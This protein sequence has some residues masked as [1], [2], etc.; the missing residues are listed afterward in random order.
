MMPT[1]WPLASALSLSAFG[2]GGVNACEIIWGSYWEGETEI[3]HFVKDVCVPQTAISDRVRP[4]RDWRVV[5]DWLCGAT[6][7]IDTMEWRWREAG[8]QISRAWRQV[9]PIGY[10][11]GIGNDRSRRLAVILNSQNETPEINSAGI[12]IDPVSATSR[13]VGT[14]D[15]W[16]VFD[17]FAS[18]SPQSGCENCQGDSGKGGQRAVI[19]LYKFKA[20]SHADLSVSPDP[21]EREGTFLVLLVSGLLIVA[22]LAYL[23]C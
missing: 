23:K 15:F 11:G 22:G 13:D 20:A 16:G 4:H 7:L 3:V 21:F 5:A 1:S 8:G 19:D 18:G 2:I 17:Q 6:K 10:K 14:F 9:C 12:R